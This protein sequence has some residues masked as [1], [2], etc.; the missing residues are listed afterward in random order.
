M[1]VVAACNPHRGNSLSSHEQNEDDKWMRGLYYVHPLHPT[2]QFLKWDYG[3]LDTCQERDYIN[4]KIKMLNWS[5]SNVEEASFTELIAESQEQMRCYASQQLRSY[6]SEGESKVVSRSCVSQ[7]DIQRVF[8]LHAWLIKGYFAELSKSDGNH[9]D[10]NHTD[11]NRRA[12][13]VA[14]F[15]VYFMRLN[16]KF[17][18]QYRRIMDTKCTIANEVNFSNAV[19]DVLEWYIDR[20]ELPLGIAKTEAL[21][22]N[23]FAIIICTVTQIP[24]IIVGAPGSSKTLSFNITVANL[25]GQESKAPL[26]RQTDKYPSLDPHYYQCS[27]RTTS[28]EI[29]TVFSRAINRQKSHLEVS[30]RI[31]CVVFMDE[32]GL[33]EESHESLKVLHYYLDNP[34]V[35]FVAI[36]N[37]VL[38][39]SKTNRAIS[40]FR[41]ESSADDLLTLAKGCLYSHQDDPQPNQNGKDFAAITYFCTQYFNFMKDKKI[42]QFFGLRDFIYFIN[43]LRRKRKFPNT[44]DAHVVL[45]ALERNFN[46]SDEFN[47]I[48]KNFLAYVS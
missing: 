42:K 22:E 19:K 37:H 21:K 31:N 41:P 8:T 36:T 34:E 5:T 28:N 29:Q 23:I 43:Y 45:E 17:R 39:A 14:L 9:T 35:S 3:S 16:A 10:C 15:V 44:I 30:L 7:R 2:L 48:C 1:F 40:L 4:A 26:F 18:E 24:L 47:A 27:I 38:D 32:A 20:I 13:L 33:P 46:G 6:L 11:C 25:K 12:L